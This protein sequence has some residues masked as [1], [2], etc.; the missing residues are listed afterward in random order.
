MRKKI[1]RL[2]AAL[3]AFIM[4]F[5]SIGFNAPTVDAAAKK[6]TKITLNKTKATLYLKQSTTLKVKSVKPGNATKNVTWKSSNPKVATVNSKGK[7]TAKKAGKTTITAI[8]KSNKKV[9]ATC[10]VTVKNPTISF[11]SKTIIANRKQGVTLKP[12]VR[13]YSKKV[14]YSISRKDKKIATVSQKGFV[15]FKKTGTVTVYAKANG[16]TAK[17]KV[18]AVN[19]TLKSVGPTSASIYATGRNSSV[20]FKAK[21]TGA[22]NKVTWSVKDKRIAK[23]NSKTGKVTPVKAG[24]TTIYAKA[25]GLTKSY[26]VTVKATSLKIS[27]TS[28]S[29]FVGQTTKLTASTVGADK[30]ITWSTNSKYITAKDGV[31]KATKVGTY[32]VYAK[33]NGLTK[34]CKVTVSAPKITL[35]KTSVV[36][37]EG[38][39]VTLTAKVSGPSKTVTW[40]TSSKDIT[41]SNG[42]VTA[43]KAGTYY[44]Y[45]KANG[46]TASCKVV[47]NKKP[48]PDKEVIKPT[49]SIV[50]NDKVKTY[51]ISKEAKAIEAV[52]GARS[53]KTTVENIFAKKARL[54]A[55]EKECNGDF[56]AMF[57][58]V[59]A[60]GRTYQAAGVTVKVNSASKDTKNITVSGA[61]V[62]VNGTYDVAVAKKGTVYT[63]TVKN[64]STT[65]VVTI[66]VTYANGQYKA[67]FNV[68]SSKFTI[69]LAKDFTKAEVVSETPVDAGITKKSVV[70]SYEETKSNFVASYNYSFLSAWNGALTSKFGVD[71]LKKIEETTITAFY[72]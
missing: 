58:K 72:K 27:K 37:I 4:L 32:T 22:T 9:K 45:A 64:V 65:K 67:V 2:L 1:L 44:V 57:N 59:G 68:M 18:K 10:K 25:N 5:T 24:T 7:V 47:V 31:V 54:L 28:V 8:S 11:G 21:A 52:N 30:K 50:N 20:T 41:V 63:V 40:T 6:A 69:T 36:L 38:Q 23:V 70:A 42:K 14:T 60:A 66:S 53:Y 34:T 13:G 3:T 33:A 56:A 16:K 43:N 19:P 15:K 12:T 26:K 55:L 71:V 29:L 49:D 17:V 62:K 51:T 39:T 61:N 48:R 35:N 46:V